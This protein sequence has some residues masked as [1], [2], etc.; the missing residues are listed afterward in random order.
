MLVMKTVRTAGT[1]AIQVATPA[2]ARTFSCAMNSTL[3]D[4]LSEK[5]QER[6]KFRI[7]SFPLHY[8]YDRNIRAEAERNRQSLL[9]LARHCSRSPNPRNSGHRLRAGSRLYG[10]HGSRDHRLCRRDRHLT[11][12]P[13]L[14]EGAGRQH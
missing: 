6:T 3:M 2:Q 8:F 5:V 1:L 14:R 10:T 9:A 11:R 12:C 7:L 4:S 13:S